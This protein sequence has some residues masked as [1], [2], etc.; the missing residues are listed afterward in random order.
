[1]ES[2]HSPE[3]TSQDASFPYTEEE[4]LPL[5]VVETR[6]KLPASVVL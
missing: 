2:L 6:L 5:T 4:A 3:L 1:M